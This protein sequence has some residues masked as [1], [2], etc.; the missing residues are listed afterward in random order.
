MAVLMATIFDHN[1]K[2]PARLIFHA[3]GLSSTFSLYRYTS[4]MFCSAVPVPVITSLV[5]I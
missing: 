4:F 5:P 1:R 3:A 2:E